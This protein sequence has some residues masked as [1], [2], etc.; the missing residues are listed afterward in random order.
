MMHT[1][2]KILEAD[3]FLEKLQQT[4]DDPDF[5]FYLSAFLSA[6]RS[7]LDIMLYDFAEHFS[8]GI[9]RD[10]KINEQNFIFVAKTFGNHSAVEFIRWWRGNQGVLINNPL[11]RKRSTRARAYQSLHTASIA[12]SIMPY[13]TRTSS[14]KA[15]NPAI[16][17]DHIRFANIFVHN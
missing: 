12:Q 4:P 8:L 5:T 2:N 14:K 1:R 10:D 16:Q 9:T 6:W 15:I 17:F 3:F 7:V 13:Y 11:W